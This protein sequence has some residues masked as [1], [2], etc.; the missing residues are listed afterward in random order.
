M[1]RVRLTN[2]NKEFV[3]SFSGSVYGS[4][5]IS[6]PSQY[7]PSQQ[8]QQKRS[9]SNLDLSLNKKYDVHP[10]EQYTGLYELHSRIENRKNP[11][12]NESLYGVNNKIKLKNNSI[13]ND[14]QKNI[15]NNN[16]NKQPEGN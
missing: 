2:N 11:N 15:H 1:D 10:S 7:H 6:T 8:F 13:T 9:L 4:G 14:N 12:L 5:R 3:Q 16:S